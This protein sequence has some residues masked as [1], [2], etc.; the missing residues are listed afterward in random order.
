MI[1]AMV[2]LE[3][4]AKVEF[5]HRNWILFSAKAP[6]FDS[7]IPH[8]LFVPRLV[9]LS[10]PDGFLNAQELN[11]LLLGMNF[12]QDEVTSDY[13]Y[14]CLVGYGANQMLDCSQFEQLYAALLKPGEQEEGAAPEGACL[15]ELLLLSSQSCRS[16]L[17]PVEPRCRDPSRCRAGGARAA[18][19][20][21]RCRD[22]RQVRPVRYGRRWLP[23]T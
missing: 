16:S 23:K 18:S 1:W 14:E 22:C 21:I 8:S 20:A 12:S 15:K 10:L 5:R 6:A 3:A 17:R 13:I 11:D 19:P 4:S 9:P 7:I 2:T